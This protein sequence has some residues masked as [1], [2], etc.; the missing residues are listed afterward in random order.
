LELDPA[1]EEARKVL[2]SLRS[3]TAATASAR[4]EGGL[5]K[6]LFGR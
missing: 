5:F 6:R 4:P 2:D 3:A 1:H